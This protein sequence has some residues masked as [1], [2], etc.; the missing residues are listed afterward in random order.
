MNHC[1]C[2]GRL[3]CKGRNQALRISREF[4]LEGNEALVRK[5]ASV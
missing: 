2:Y 5:G 3:F 1:E 4:E